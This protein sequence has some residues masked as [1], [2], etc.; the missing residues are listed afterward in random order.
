MVIAY[1][2]LLEAVLR[3]EEAVLDTQLQACRALQGAGVVRAVDAEAL[4]LRRRLGHDGG[5]FVG[6]GVGSFVGYVVAEKVNLG[7][8]DAMKVMYDRKRP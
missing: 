3:T 7:V 1:P 4:L 5:C 2:V 8:L 6:G